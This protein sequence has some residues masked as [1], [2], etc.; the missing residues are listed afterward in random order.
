MSGMDGMLG[1]AR[2][3]AIVGAAVLMLNLALIGW[4]A[5]AAPLLKALNP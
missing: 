3:V 1:I 5:I 4:Q 2:I